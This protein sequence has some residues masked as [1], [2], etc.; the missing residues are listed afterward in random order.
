MVIYIIF[1]M[2]CRYSSHCMFHFHLG[3]GTKHLIPQK[4]DNTFISLQNMVRCA[5]C[6]TKNCLP[7]DIDRKKTGKYFFSNK[8]HTKTHPEKSY[9]RLMGLRPTVVMVVKWCPDQCYLRYWKTC[10]SSSALRAKLCEDNL[11]IWWWFNL[12]Y[13]WGKQRIYY[14]CK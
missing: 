7:K 11:E 6:G 1:W 8:K 10:H 13:F 12:E 3:M 2:P 5:I 4:K 14:I 9:Q